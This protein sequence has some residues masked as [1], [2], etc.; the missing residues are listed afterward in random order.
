VAAT[1]ILLT[2][3]CSS[4]IGDLQ[5]ATSTVAISTTPDPTT[6]GAAPVIVVDPADYAARSARYPS[7]GF[8]TPSSAWICVIAT[9]PSNGDSAACAANP[10]QGPLSV[11]GLPPATNNDGTTS[12]RPPNVVAI[13][14]SA[15]TSVERLDHSIWAD[16]TAPLVLPDG[17][18]LSVGG[19][20][21]NTQST[22]VSCREDATGKGFSISSTGYRPTYTDV[23]MR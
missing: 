7:W 2:V 4:T 17:A 1:G 13:R 15:D 3:A 18:L 23:P 14:E 21:C 6:A 9:A 12:S 16:A 19:M 20:S 8:V 10:D 22:V 11:P 5:E